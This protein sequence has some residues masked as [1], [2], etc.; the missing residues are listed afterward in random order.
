MRR[1]TMLHETEEF[2]REGREGK[3]R[4]EGFDKAD[5]TVNLIIGVGGGNIYTDSEGHK[6]HTSPGAH[7]SG[8]T[9][10]RCM[11]VLIIN[12]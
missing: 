1:W 5:S 2:E 11:Y 12:D 9:L 7:E 4:K 6:S 8:A 3:R 10:P